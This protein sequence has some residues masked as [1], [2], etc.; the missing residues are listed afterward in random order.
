M[1]PAAAAFLRTLDGLRPD[2]ELSHHFL[3]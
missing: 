1:G 2:E 3:A